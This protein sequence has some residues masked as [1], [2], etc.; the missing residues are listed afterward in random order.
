MQKESQV[1]S[2]LQSLSPIPLLISWHQNQVSFISYLKKG[3]SLHVRLHRLFLEA[4]SP[5]LEALVSFLLKKDKKAQTIVRRMAHFYFSKVK[6]MPISLNP[7]GKVY[8]LQKIC[9]EIKKDFFP[10]SFNVSIG[11]SNTSRVKSFR[12]ITF[13]T[14]DRHRNQIRIHSLLDDEE[15]PLYFLRFL[16]YHE[17]LHAICPSIIDKRGFC[18]SHTAEFKQMEK[19]FPSYEE[20]K[21][22]SKTS[23]KFLKAKVMHGRS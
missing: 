8:D 14:Y 17:M 4:P 9:S 20:A 16:I 12:S 7:V 23:L 6:V 2:F 21:K 10:S 13:G 19:K 22:W 5:V 18:R 3:H 1:C 11:W 15:V